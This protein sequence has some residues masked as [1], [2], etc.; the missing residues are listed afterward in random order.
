MR[1]KSHHGGIHYVA[2]D[3]FNDPQR[4]DPK[5]TGSAY[6]WD[7]GLLSASKESRQEMKWHFKAKNPRCH[8]PLA[9]N[10]E[11]KGKEHEV[12]ARPDADLICLKPMAY[13]WP[14][15][16]QRL[17]QR[18]PFTSPRSPAKHLAF[19]FDPSW[20]VDLPMS[21]NTLC[22]E[23]TPRGFFARTWLQYVGL[24]YGFRVFLIDRHARGPRVSPKAKDWRFHDMHH[25]YIS[26]MPWQ[27][28]CDNEDEEKQTSRYFWNHLDKLGSNMR[29]DDEELQSFFENHFLNIRC[30]LQI[31]TCRKFSEPEFPEMEEKEEDEP[32]QAVGDIDSR[33]TWS[34]E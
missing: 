2:L 32:A 8:L 7:A 17:P 29:T 27:I 30:F 20:N 9:L 28:V 19:E 24:G 10:V 22:D 25:E 5:N 31:L 33:W 18:L 14:V 3:F 16:W 1:P 26:T 21:L 11:E 6:E 23:E 15:N 34:N 13:E 12:L 4:P